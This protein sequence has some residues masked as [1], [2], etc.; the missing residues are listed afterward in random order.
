MLKAQK[1]FKNNTNANIIGDNLRIEKWAELLWN[2][3]LI[4]EQIDAI[5]VANEVWTNR[6]WDW[7]STIAN[8][9]N[10]FLSINNWID[11]NFL[12]DKDLYKKISLYEINK[13]LKLDWKNV[14]EYLVLLKNNNFTYDAFSVDMYVK[15]LAFKEKWLDLNWIINNLKSSNKEINIYNI[16]YIF[17]NNINF[18]FTRIDLEYR[19]VSKILHLMH[20]KWYFDWTHN[21]NLESFYKYINTK[22]ISDIGHRLWFSIEKYFNT[23]WFDPETELKNILK[24]SDK[25]K[26]LKE[27][28]N[29]FIEQKVKLSLIIWKVEDICSKNPQ[30]QLEYLITQ[31]LKK[32]EDFSKKQK[33]EI[34]KKIENYYIKVNIIDSL[35]TEFKWKENELLEKVYWIKT[36]WK[37]EVE[38]YSSAI[39]FYVSDFS[40]YEKL[41]SSKNASSTLGFKTSYSEIKELK[42]SITFLKWKNKLKWSFS[43]EMKVH[44]SR[45]TLNDI[46][47]IWDNNKLDRT[48]DEIIAYLTNGSTL[49]RIKNSL[50]KKDWPY[51]YYAD[52]SWK[53]NYT[54]LWSNHK[55]K[56]ARAIDNV[57]LIKKM[58]PNNYIDLLSV[59]DINHWSKIIENEL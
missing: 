52:L 30:I 39:V 12:L 17:N 13:M 10:N 7:I 33:I 29:N 2:K 51:N 22:V 24:L 47:F 6:K 18:D 56:V 50:T 28:K 48:K 43:H 40:D 37:I 16:M 3:E 34:I 27:Y 15:Y 49:S 41:Y 9:L 42:W 25:K 1:E 36:K 57:Y 55:N 54:K 23:N 32:P 46:I 19:K 21:K 35:I 31:V 20:L 58:F 44:E 45:H 59:T 8:Q 4:Q 11:L 38:K 53:D 14:K 26:W 5:I